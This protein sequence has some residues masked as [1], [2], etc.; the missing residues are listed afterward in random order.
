MLLN[1]LL[2]GT[3]VQLA[4]DRQA[5]VDALGERLAAGQGEEA[6]LEELRAFKEQHVFRVAAAETLGVLPLMHVSDYLTHLAEAILEHTLKW[7]WEQCAVQGGGDGRPFIVV[8]YGKLGGV[9][10]G[11]GSDLDLVFLHDLP[12]SQSRFVHRLAQKLLHCL[13]APTYLGPLYEIDMRLRPSGNAGTMV[14]SLRA[15]EDY[16]RNRAWVWEHQALVRARAVAGDAELVQRFEEVRVNLLRQQRDRDDLRS[17]II[18]MRQR[19]ADHQGKDEDLKSGFGG[20]VDIEFMVQ[21]LVLAYAH[22]EPSLAV[23]SDNVRILEAAAETGLLAPSDAESLTRGLLGVAGATA[24]QR[25][26]S[27]RPGWRRHRHGGPPG[28][29]RQG[30]GAVVRRLEGGGRLRLDSLATEGT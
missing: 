17:A 5:L 30:V 4:L 23:H 16:Q 20:I 18:K 24:P 1:L 27:K 9:E 3:P 22:R 7:T 28:G 10:L 11:P 21:Y 8:G 15:F 2:E 29:G 26:G 14:S 13:T 25:A 6:V 19:M 12:L